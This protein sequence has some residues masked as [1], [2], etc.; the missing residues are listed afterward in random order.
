MRD[1]EE[2]KLNTSGIHQFVV[3]GFVLLVSKG[4]KF[5]VNGR[6]PL[7]AVDSLKPWLYSHTEE[8]SKTNKPNNIPYTLRRVVIMIIYT[9]DMSLLAYLVIV[10]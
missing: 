10:M 2:N 9:C 5:T 8:Q 3:H 1:Y 6:G 4:V 7:A